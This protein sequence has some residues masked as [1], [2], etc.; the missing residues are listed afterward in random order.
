MRLFCVLP[1]FSLLFGARASSL[2]SRTPTAHPLDARDLI[3]VCASIDTD[4]VVP[5]LLGG[6]LSAAGALSQFNVP[7]STDFQ[8]SLII[9]LADVCLCL[10]AL[11]L[12]LETNLVALLAVTIAGQQVTSDILTNLVRRKCHSVYKCI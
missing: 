4:L 10:S 2:D 7:L 3:D 12:F 5:D 6:I 11:P 9:L 8:V 1:I